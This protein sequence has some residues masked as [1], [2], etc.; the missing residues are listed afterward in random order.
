L[1]GEEIRAILRPGVTEQEI[2]G[3]ADRLLSLAA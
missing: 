3:T 1:L 2:Q